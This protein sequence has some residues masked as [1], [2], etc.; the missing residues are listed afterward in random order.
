VEFLL[1]LVGLSGK[2]GFLFMKK[3]NLD[4]FLENSFPIHTSD[5]KHLQNWRMQFVYPSPSDKKELVKSYDS[6]IEYVKGGFILS[7]SNHDWFNLLVVDKIKF[8]KFKNEVFPLLKYKTFSEKHATHL[9]K[10]DL[11]GLEVAIYR[12]KLNIRDEF[13]EKLCNFLTVENNYWFEN[14]GRNGY[15]YKQEFKGWKRKEM[16]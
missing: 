3:M 9:Y 1:A 14:F 4:W 13:V 15:N 5:M 6:D 16:I 11:D 7:Y 8:E 12:W 2:I 10:Y